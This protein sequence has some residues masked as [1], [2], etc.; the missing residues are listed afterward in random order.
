MIDS[1]KRTYEFIKSN[2]LSVLMLAAVISI[3][4][5]ALGFIQQGVIYLIYGLLFLAT[6]I[7]GGGVALL[8]QGGGVTILGIV[9][10]AVGII[11]GIALIV[12]LFAM[13]F[14]FVSFSFGIQI[15]ISEV[16]NDIK[17]E[18]KATFKGTFSRLR[19][20]WKRYLKG[21]MK[22]FGYYFLMTLPFILIL[23]IVYGIVIAF[24]IIVLSST[25]PSG[26]TITLSIL[27]INLASILLSMMLIFLIP[28]LQFIIESSAM[29]MAEGKKA[30]ESVKLGFKD[31]FKS[32]R[33]VIY[34]IT[35]VFFLMMV[36]FLIFPL[37]I[38]AQG[39]IPVI[40]KTFLL[41]NRDMFLD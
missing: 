20:D 25:D 9:I 12:V 24:F 28:I 27:A 35:G 41:A 22:L 37:I 21:G 39:A 29:R 15:F 38:I 19:E 32:T 17:H 18:R 11:L 3:V 34:Y 30:R 10:M 6:L 31:L 5:W 16:L 40:T 14:I 8:A 13:I 23:N 7:M 26:E 4:F 2:F 1:Y 33:G 36:I